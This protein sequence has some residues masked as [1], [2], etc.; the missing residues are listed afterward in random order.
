MGI[1]DDIGSDKVIKFS[2]ALECLIL[3]KNEISKS[4]A[5]AERCAYILGS[6]SKERRKIQESVKG[7]YDLRSGI[8][9]DGNNSITDK[10]VDEFRELA[11]KCLF[12]ILEIKDRSNLM[13]TERLKK[14]IQE[15]KI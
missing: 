1:D 6:N 15:K 9:H 12:K 4:L 7:L 13:G 10:D 5:L 3:T 14:L 2:I 11:T 8:A